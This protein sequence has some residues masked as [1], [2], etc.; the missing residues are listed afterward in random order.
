M[1]RPQSHVEQPVFRWGGA[2]KWVGGGQL[3]LAAVT[4]AL[5]RRGREWAG[6]LLLS[7]IL[8]AAVRSGR[9]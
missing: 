4:T 6:C 8:V 3:L 2:V 9:G 7:I 1:K 5:R